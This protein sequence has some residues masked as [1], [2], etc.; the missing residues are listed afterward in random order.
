MGK[1]WRYRQIWSCPSERNGV[2]CEL[3]SSGL[4]WSE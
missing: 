3:L 4:L 1:H 2:I